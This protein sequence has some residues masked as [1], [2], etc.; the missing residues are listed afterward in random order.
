MENQPRKWAGNHSKL[1][2]KF[3]AGRGR[4][5]KEFARR[6]LKAEEVE[7]RR[8]IHQLI[9]S[10]KIALD[11]H[12]IEQ[13]LKAG[14]NGTSEST[15]VSSSSSQFQLFEDSEGDNFVDSTHDKTNSKVPFGSYHLS[16][17]LHA[18]AI[19]NNLENHMQQ[20]KL[21]EDSNSG[22]DRSRIP[23]RFWNTQRT[24]NSKKQSNK[25]RIVHGKYNPNSQPMSQLA[26]SQ[27]LGNVYEARPQQFMSAQTGTKEN[28]T[29]S[30]DAWK[31]W[32]DSVVVHGSID[33]EYLEDIVV[34]DDNDN[35]DDVMVQQYVNA[36]HDEQMSGSQPHQSKF[37]K[38]TPSLIQELGNL[39]STV[40]A[41]ACQVP[42]GTVPNPPKGPDRWGGSELSEINQPTGWGEIVEDNRNW[43]DDGTSVLWGAPSLPFGASGGWSWNS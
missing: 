32:E 25:P 23:P 43:Y 34:V 9:L 33:E 18:E 37:S 11:K 7:K 30:S 13:Q 36:L 24:R 27:A 16:D 12:S 3:I 8:Q 31:D 35:L 2:D 1:T 22:D 21:V 26:K 42:P 5:L 6:T 15:S 10:G 41:D 29:K 38:V 4:A 28:Q 14:S 20:L 40:N 19:S 17:R 39:K